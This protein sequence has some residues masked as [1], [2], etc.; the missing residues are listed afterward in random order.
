MPALV[1]VGKSSGTRLD[2]R[3]GRSAAEGNRKKYAGIELQLTRADKSP[4]AAKVLT[5]AGR[6]QADISQLVY[7]GAIL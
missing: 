1:E 7:N 5:D 2:S 3:S 6:V 4:T